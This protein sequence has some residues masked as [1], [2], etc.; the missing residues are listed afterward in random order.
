MATDGPRVMPGTRVKSWSWKWWPGTD[1]FAQRI[2]TAQLPEGRG[3]AQADP[4]QS[5]HRHAFAISGLSS[6]ATNKNPAEAVTCDINQLFDVT[7]CVVGKD[8]GPRVR[9]KQR[10]RPRPSHSGNFTSNSIAASCSGAIP[11]FR[12]NGSQR[13]SSWS[14]ANAGSTVTNTTCGTA[15][16]SHWKALSF[17]PRTA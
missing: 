16:S 7:S 3:S 12:R 13:G 10:E 5:N 2:R 6:G 11:S 4:S 14:L 9:P 1:R 8:P 17:S 15:F